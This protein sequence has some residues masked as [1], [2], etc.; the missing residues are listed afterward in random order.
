M[1]ATILPGA[2]HLADLG[3]WKLAGPTHSHVKAD[4]FL[5]YLH[6]TN[7]NQRHELLVPLDCSS[8]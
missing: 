3:C 6:F 2:L 5:R 4:L 8:L 1:H 7:H